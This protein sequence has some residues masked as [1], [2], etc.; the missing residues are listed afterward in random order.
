MSDWSVAEE[1][2]LGGR[3]QVVITKL[4]PGGRQVDA[5]LVRGVPTQI[6]SLS[7]ADP[8]GDSTA[9]LTFPGITPMDDLQAA[10]LVR[11]L[12]H[13]SN[14]DIY[15]IPALKDWDPDDFPD[16]PLVVNELTGQLDVITPKILRAGSGL[17]RTLTDLRIK[18]WEG[19][20]ASLAFSS[21]E[22]QATLQVQCQGALFQLDRYLQ[23]PFFP[24]Q[25]WPL[26]LLIADA[27]DS[28]PGQPRRKPHLRTQPLKILFPD[29]WKL[30]VPNYTGQDAYTPVAAPGT[31]WTGY[32]SRQT[33]A[34]EHTLTG[35]VQ[36]QLTVMITDE[37]AGV[38]I[39]NQWTVQHQR[40]QALAA[41]TSGAQFGP[42]GRQP[43]LMIRDRFRTPDFDLVYGIRGLDLDLAADSTQSENVIYGDG[44]S[45]DGTAWRNAVI[46]NDGKRTDY[47]PLAASRQVYPYGDTGA[48]N[49]TTRPDGWMD[50]SVPAPTGFVSG[51]F[52]SEAYTKFGS[53]FDQPAAMTTAARMLA[54]DQQPGWSGTIT[55]RSDPTAL[56]PRW[57]IR[58][59]MTLRLKNF[60][61]TGERGMPFHISSVEMNPMEGSVVLTVDT[62]YR[63]LL[64]VE[65]SISRTRDPLTPVKMLQVNRTS[66]MIEDIQAPWDYAAGSGYIPK[67][68]KAFHDYKPGNQSFPYVDWRQKHPPLHYASWYIKC[69]ASAATRKGRWSGPIPILT[70]EKDTVIRTEFAVCDV[71]GRPLAVPFHVSLYYVNVTV[72]AMPRDKNGPSPYIN[73]AFES[74]NPRTGQPWPA[75]N[76]LAP[77]QSFIIGWGNRSNGQFN[78]AG[79]WP[80]SEQY[81]ARP[82]GLFVDEAPWSFDNTNNPNYNKLA[83][84]GQRQTASAITIYAMF[85]C[86][87]KES[88]YFHGRLF[89][90]NPG[91]S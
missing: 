81:G 75:G 64:T 3:F 62:R 53:G 40:Q 36:D 86:E 74:I 33:G 87:Y 85:Y 82:S 84:P 20:I 72:A 68:S 44:T 1:Q 76:F 54:R 47:L 5:T 34:W 21:G 24:P 6:G 11:W 70:S 2:H 38:T 12:D 16:E 69:K 19:F 50:T 51:A 73:G 31:M 90:Q 59:G 8:F 91:T 65:E 46:S 30:K 55:L 49:D 83:K 29:E 26:E 4:L 61:G 79:F 52:A 14:V 45:I 10:D 13:Y 48:Q 17:T 67:A 27:F 71:Y 25:P 35:F 22:S 42:G 89:R 66:V 32:T 28:A 37:R 9:V 56:L 60:A 77:D 57:L 80:G 23:K 63:D 15:W 58:A 7:S 18:V 78:R 41:P 88:V 39:G 43:V